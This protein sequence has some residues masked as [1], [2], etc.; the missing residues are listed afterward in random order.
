M[1]GRI[2]RRYLLSGQGRRTEVWGQLPMF[3]FYEPSALP[4]LSMLIQIRSHELQFEARCLE[5]GTTPARP[6]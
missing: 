6:E 3:A 2:K 1:N 4:G 5:C